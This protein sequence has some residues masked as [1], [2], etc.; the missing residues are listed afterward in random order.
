ME[1]TYRA[2]SQDKSSREVSLSC[3][4]FLNKWFHTH[5]E[6]RKRKRKKVVRGRG[7]GGEGEDD[8]P[9]SARILS[10]LVSCFVSVFLAFTHFLTSP[11]VYYLLAVI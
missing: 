8:R 5:T 1:N 10:F 3:P 9:R 2:R 7:N 6:K 4:S 11:H